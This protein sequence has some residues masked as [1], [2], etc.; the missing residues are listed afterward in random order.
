[1]NTGKELLFFFSALGTFNGFVLSLYFFFLTKK[2]YLTN[3]LLGALVLAISICVGKS[4]A[5]YFNLGLPLIFSQFGFSVWFFIGPLL[6]FFLR[7]ATD[8]TK[9]MPR[10]WK[11]FLATL[12]GVI[13]LVGIIYPYETQ[14]NVW[15]N[16]LVRGIFA[17][18]SFFLLASIIP[19]RNHFEKLFNKDEKLSG[20][21]RWLLGIYGGNVVIHLFYFLSLINAPFTTCLN[22]AIVFSFLL[23]MIIT[24]LLYRKKTDDLF[25]FIP[26]KTNIK[27]MDPALSSLIQHRLEKVMQTERAYKDPELKLATLAAK[28]G[29][30]AHQL[31]QFLNEE[32]KNNF[33]AYINGCRIEEACALI[34]AGNKLT[35]EAIGYEVGFNS[36]STFF[37]AFKKHTGMTPLTF[38]QQPFAAGTN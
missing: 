17:Q 37:A 4:V 15:C 30:S 27:K 28:I 20:Q 14:Q 23:Y 18:W 22:G 10:S 3:Y 16:Y 7:A 35:L 38:Q 29:V 21:E 11:I 19:L 12:F 24:I 2:K 31:S 34:A 9:E 32:L 13:A 36:K 8:G 25:N 33:T 26:E 5:E 1:M 6:Y